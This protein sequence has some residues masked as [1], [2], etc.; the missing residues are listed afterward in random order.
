MHTILYSSHKEA[1]FILSLP[2]A[3]LAMG[4][5]MANETLAHDKQSSTWRV[6]TLGLPPCF[7]WDIAAR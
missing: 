5:T 4:L 3:G 6:C 1:E 2:K 7:S